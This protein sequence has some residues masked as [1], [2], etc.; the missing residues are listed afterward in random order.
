[1]SKLCL[2]LLIFFILKGWFISET[3]DIIIHGENEIICGGTA[4]FEAD[5]K[6]VESSC[7]SV[8]WQKQR[9]NVIE[10]INTRMERYS[11]STK[12]KL[13]IKTVCKEDEGEY[14]AVLS[15][16]SKGSY[17]KSRNTIRLHVLGGK[18][19]QSFIS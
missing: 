2:I 10:R 19:K 17:F 13:V 16:E 8:A 4:Q 6:K 5:V 9:G 3:P 12:K 1:M 7:W 18:L 15:L 11:G 14:Q